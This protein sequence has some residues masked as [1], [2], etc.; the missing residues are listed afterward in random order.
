M[1]E[2]RSPLLQNLWNKRRKI[3]RGLEGLEGGDVFP[4]NFFFPVV[5]GNCLLAQEGAPTDSWGVEQG[6][7]HLSSGHGTWR[8]P[9]QEAMLQLDRAPGAC[10]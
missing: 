1:E 9:A 7:G 6:P 10:A 3:S 8:R 5:V 4:R 2:Q